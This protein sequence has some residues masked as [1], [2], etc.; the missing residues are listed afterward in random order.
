MNQSDGLRERTSQ[1]K[2]KNNTSK[3]QDKEIKEIVEDVVKVLKDEYSDLDFEVVKEMKLRDIS[4]MLE[5][6]P[7]EPVGERSSIKPD[8]G[9]MY[10]KIK[11][12]DEIICVIEE[13]SQGTNDK[14]FV[15]GQPKQATGNAIERLAKNLK[16]IELL[17][18]QEK[19]MP[20]LVF[21]D[22]CDFDVSETIRDRVISMFHFL[23]N[24]K[25]NL[26]K[27]KYGRAGSYY[28]RGHCYTDGI[29]LSRWTEAE[30]FEVVLDLCKKSINYYK[31]K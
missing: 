14:R 30:K 9:F 11:G 5:N 26:H 31:T 17:F 25:I 20:F 16:C 2:P 19:I 27:D 22:G 18:S 15:E 21:I 29:Q 24:Q 28:M 4:K 12:R 6:V 3:Q 23:P 8:G 1:H 13:K 7:V 10:L